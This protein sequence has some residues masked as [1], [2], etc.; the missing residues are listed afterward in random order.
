MTTNT[1]IIPEHDKHEHTATLDCWCYPLQ[2]DGARVIH[3]AKDC[4]EL[5]ERHNIPTGKRWLLI[6][7]SSPTH[8]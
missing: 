2:I 3:N 7:E 5:K 4:R 1:H 6:P 8:T